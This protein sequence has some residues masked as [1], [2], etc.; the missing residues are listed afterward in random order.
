M[1]TLVHRA[2]TI[3]EEL[4]HDF[5]V[6]IDVRD[7]QGTPCLSHDPIISKD[8]VIGLLDW[9][10]KYPNYSMYA[11]N[12]KSDGNE[13]V[14]TNIM[15]TIVGKDRWFVFDMSFPCRTNYDAWKGNIVDRCSD[16]GE[17][18]NPYLTNCGMWSDRWLWN[19]REKNDLIISKMLS[20]DTKEKLSHYYVSPELHCGADVKKWKI[21][22]ESYLE[23]H[24]ASV[25]Q[26]ENFVGICTDFYYEAKEFFK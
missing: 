17:D 21:G 20:T 9:I 1:I 14:I 5:G 8:S 10:M 7:A 25:K 15:N 6:E 13:R 16:L 18:I 4:D 19:K 2:H 22:N 11:L 26:N 3:E 24:W 12:I 23:A